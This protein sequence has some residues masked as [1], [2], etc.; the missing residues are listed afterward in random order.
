VQAVGLATGEAVGDTGEPIVEET[1]TEAIIDRTEETVE[2]ARTTTGDP[3]EEPTDDSDGAVSTM[4]RN[5]NETTESEGTT[6]STDGSADEPT[7]AVDPPTSIENGARSG[8][9]AT[10]AIGVESARANEETDDATAVQRASDR[11]EVDDDR[12]VEEPGGSDEAVPRSPVESAV[13]ERALETRGLPSLERLDSTAVPPPEM[14]SVGGA[15]DAGSFEPANAMSGA[16]Q[17]VIS[18]L[19]RIDFLTGGAILGVLVVVGSFAESG[20]ALS[21]ATGAGAATLP[22]LVVATIRTWLLRLAALAGYS[23]YDFDDPL[24]NENRAAVFETI[25]ESPGIN[26]TSLV[27]ETGLAESTVRYHLRVLEHE[28][29]LETA[30]ILGCRRFA[31]RSDDVELVAALE[32]TA[33]KEVLETL[34]ADEPATGTTLADALE[35]DPSTVSHHLSRLAEAGLIEREADG[36]ALMNSL[37]PEVREAFSEVEVHSNPQQHAKVDD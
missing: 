6:G 9:A 30:K 10:D 18:P 4:T 33:T 35:K 12:T 15:A 29:L 8:T 36:P 1:D 31:R 20:A 23:R 17:G 3:G 19:E 26:L 11:S 5:A 37:V 32:E 27:E 25:E 24:E 13:F 21:T 2:G 22:Q 16:N 28:D 14:A 34:F 7:E